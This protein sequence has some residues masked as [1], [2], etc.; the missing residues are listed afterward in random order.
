[1]DADGFVS[2]NSLGDGVTVAALA[3]AIEAEGIYTWDR[4]GRFSKYEKG[5]DE[6][7]KALDALA[8]HYERYYGFH[9][10]M[11]DDEE[12]EIDVDSP[13]SIFN[14]YGWSRAMLPDFARSESKFPR[15]PAR[16]VHG[17]VEFNNLRIVGA[18]LGC[19]LGELGVDRH[20]DFGSQTDLVR[21]LA[22]KMAGF[23]GMSPRN[24]E[25]KFAKARQLLKES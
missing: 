3:T 14:L 1:M 12:Y 10:G 22:D 7:K 4:F 19:I 6:S 18:L 8:R 25:D 23:G 21:F 16:P 24:L 5:T 17:K 20:P 13:D 15:S 9:G 2:L 11:P